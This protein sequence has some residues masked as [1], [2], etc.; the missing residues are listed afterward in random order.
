[1]Q[2]LGKASHLTSGGWLI[3]ECER[4]PLV[5]ETIFDSRHRPVGRIDE[6]IGPWKGPLA[7]VRLERGVDTKRLL[8]QKVF[9]GD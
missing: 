2:P 4:L 1:M 5:P 6:L 3:V 8:G 7:R 9:T